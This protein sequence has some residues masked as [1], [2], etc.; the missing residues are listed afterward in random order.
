[1]NI[2][3]VKAYFYIILLPVLLL[4]GPFQNC[5]CTFLL[6]NT[7][8]MFCLLFSFLFDNS[9]NYLWVLFVTLIV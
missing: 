2:K 3:L 7:F 5:L 8:Q 4:Q 6:A 9:N 1:M